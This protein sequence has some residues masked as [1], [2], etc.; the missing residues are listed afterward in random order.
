MT[1]KNPSTLLL[2]SEED[3]LWLTEDPEFVAEWKFLMSQ[4]I[5]KGNKIKIIHTVNRSLDEMLSA[6][7]QW[8]PLYMSGAIESYYYPK[9]RDGLFKRTL[10]LAPDTAAVVSSAIGAS[11][12]NTANYLFTDKSILFS[13]IDEFQAYLSLCR[14][15]IHLFTKDNQEKFLSALSEFENEY[16]DSIIKTAGLSSI[17]MPVELVSGILSRSHHPNCKKILTYQ[18]K[19][20]VLFEKSLEA[21]NFTEIISLPETEEIISGKTRIHFFDILNTDELFYTPQEYVL[22]LQN[23]IR[24]LETYPNYHVFMD[25][26]KIS[27]HLIIY[28]KG[29]TGVIIAKC[30]SP[31]VLFGIKENN[32]T[33]AFWS[34]MTNMI[35]KFSKDKQ[36]KEKIIKQLK[37]LM[38]SLNLNTENSP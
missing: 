5:A 19:R 38:N 32:M 16:G 23:I 26:K 7:I 22:H 13:L 3:M 28:T 9:H 4:I 24:L 21:N 1:Q 20:T 15:L 10:F 14:P 30:E 17:T 8:L 6:I 31:S 29:E 27:E 18:R 36:S 2:Y 25:T 11:S 12:E 37:I 33:S 35:N 34:Y